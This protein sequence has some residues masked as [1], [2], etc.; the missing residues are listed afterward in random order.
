MV[1]YVGSVIY[2]NVCLKSSFKL[3]SVS[4]QHQASV[5]VTRP[6]QFFE[7]K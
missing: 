1:L 2:L 4:S 7:M 6:G 5:K 3:M